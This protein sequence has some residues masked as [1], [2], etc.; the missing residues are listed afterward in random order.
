M[1]RVDRDQAKR[2]DD[3][4]DDAET[5]AARRRIDV[6]GP[7]I[8]VVENAQ[9]QYQP[10]GHKRNPK[11]ERE[12]Q[13][14]HAHR[15]AP[16]RRDRFSRRA[17]RAKCITTRT[18]AGHA[19]K[20]DA[21]AS[22]QP[23]QRRGNRRIARC[24]RSFQVVALTEQPFKPVLAHRPTVGERRR[25]GGIESLENRPRRDTDTG[26]EDHG[27]K[28]VKARQD[29]DP[30][31]DSAHAQRTGIET[32]R[33]ISTECQPDFGQTVERPVQ[34]PQPVQ[35]P[36][37]RRRIGRTAAQSGLDRDLLVEPDHGPVGQAALGLQGP[38]GLQDQVGAIRN[39]RAGCLA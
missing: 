34:P 5:A 25:L 13:Q 1:R 2:Q 23:V 36:Q 33:D 18:R 10:G 6:I 16:S 32:G 9:A 8:G 17:S 27:V 31:P 37:R 3:A 20:G 11:R 24:G 22:T 19:G 14:R 26:I 4:D 38:G 7:G 29:V 28:S 39:E 35:R 30:V 21:I 15:A 12:R